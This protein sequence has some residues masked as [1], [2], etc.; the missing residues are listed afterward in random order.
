MPKS[1]PPS[2]REIK[3]RRQQAAFV[4]RDDQITL[5]RRN[6]ALALDDDRRSMIFGINGQGGVGKTTLLRRYHELVTAQHGLSALVNDDYLDPIAVMEQIARQCADRGWRLA[7]FAERAKVYRQRRQELEADPDAPQGLAGFVGRI[8]AKGGLSLV[9]QIPVGGPVAADLIDEDALLRQADDWASF[10][11]RKVGNKDEVRLLN[12]PV[13]LLTPLFLADIN[14]IADEQLVMLQ[15]DTFERTAPTLEEWLLHLI[16]SDYGDLPASLLFVIAGRDPLDYNRWLD[17]ESLLT[18]ISLEPFSDAE[19]R[20]YI[21]SK[22]I[23]DER[24]VTIILTLSGRLPLLVSMLADTNPTDTEQLA[25]PTDTAVDRFLKWVDDPQRRQLAM[26]AA[27]PRSF[28]RDTIAALAPDLDTASLFAWL[29]HNTFVT[30]R[31]SGWSHHEVV[32]SH[33]LRYLKRES[34]QLWSDLHTRLATFHEAASTQL[35]LTEQQTHRDDAW[36][37]HTIEALYH[38]LCAA[39]QHAL[40][41]ALRAIL[42]TLNKNADL[43]PRYAE[44]LRDAGNDLLST[45]LQT[46]G[47]RIQ[48]LI[49]ARTDKN[50]NESIAQL[51][52]ILAHPHLVR[53]TTYARGLAA[54]AQNYYLLKQYD[55]ALADLNLAI[56]LDPTY[57]R[58]LTRRSTIYRLQQRNDEALID[59]NSALDTDPSATH[60]VLRGDF[61]RL[62]KCYAEALIDLNHAIA[63][64]PTY[65]GSFAVRGAVY[66]AQ[67]R[68]EDALTDFDHVL[69]LDAS[70]VWTLV[71]RGKLH[72]SQKR[73][74]QAMADFDRAI[75]LDPVST[76]A[77]AERGEFNR[78]QKRYDQALADFDRAIEIDPLYSWALTQRGL[79][80]QAEH[81]NDQAL[82]DFDR[83]IKIDPLYS[84]ALTQRGGFHTSQKRYDQAL[85]D[86]DRA[87]ELNPISTWALLERADLHTSQKRY[88]QALAD[89][90]RAIEL[91]PSNA[92]AFAHRGEM[93]KSQKHYQQALSDFDHA[94]A[95]RPDYVWAFTRR[96]EVYRVQKDYSKALADFQRAIEI[97]ATYDWA[98]GRIGRI[99]R[100]QRRFTEACAAFEQASQ[101]LPEND[102]YFYHQALTLFA[103]GLPEQAQPHIINAIQRATAKAQ[104]ADASKTQS[105]LALY[106]LLAGDTSAQQRYHDLLANNPPS[107]TLSDALDDLDD[108]I[109]LLPQH[110][111]AS[112]LRELIQHHLNASDQD[113]P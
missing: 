108:L 76:W 84:W 62:R 36:Q 37:T 20:A 51:S 111:I 72:R 99:Y 21:A 63:L 46:W 17:H 16:D 3:A 43:L 41:S 56:A 113:Q 39:P 30:R 70:D 109:E 22:N 73:Y 75:E 88:N 6:L 77:L 85:A 38:R 68:Y 18:R 8:V 93:Y 71:Q 50:R 87:I 45:D 28:N 34:D 47:T 64:D 60:L 23:L 110:P 57:T 89:F 78:F 69:S 106:H 10:V 65:T 40:P 112:A 95:L 90:D 13:A 24:I 59:L 35:G 92:R 105:H 33:M 49:Q 83:A 74:D 14:D 29:I 11:A 102:R 44:A 15:F 67:Q 2:Y 31:A 80:H 58:A 1:R 54:R 91:E 101:L 5:F 55:E 79:L 104:E 107:S 9:R 52:H 98:I 12:D 32:R 26:Q 81:R 7:T 19:A 42:V 94:I 27:V 4:G 97:D 48:Q 100:T 53:D 96:G 86:F 82:A 66:H 61:Y 103:A 25:D